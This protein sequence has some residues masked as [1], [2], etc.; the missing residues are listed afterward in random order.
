M[1]KFIKKLFKLNETKSLKKEKTVKDLQIFDDIWVK[2]DN[3][4][5][6]GWIWDISRRCITVV[7]GE[8]LRDFK[9]QIPRPMNVTEIV[10]GDKV[11]YCNE[12]KDDNKT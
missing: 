3:E 1:F 11:L 5:F 6:K 8:G 12:Q 7:Y 9:F 4:I 2:E 10:Q